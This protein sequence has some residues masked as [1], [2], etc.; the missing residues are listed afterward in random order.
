MSVPTQMLPPDTKMIEMMGG[1]MY[2][3]SLYFGDG[4]RFLFGEPYKTSVEMLNST[5]TRPLCF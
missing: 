5:W 3:F 1:G 2:V 4:G